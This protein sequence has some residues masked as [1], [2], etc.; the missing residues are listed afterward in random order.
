MAITPDNLSELSPTDVATTYAIATQYMAET[1]PGIETAR[2]AFSDL[3]LLPLSQLLAVDQLTFSRLQQS[4][5]LLQIQ[6][7]PALADTSIVDAAI[8]NYNITRE[9]GTTATGSVTVVVSQPVPVVLAAGVT[10][11]AGNQQFVTTS[12]IV[13]SPVANPLAGPNDVVMSPT[14][15]GNYSFTVPA[16][17]SAA[18]VAGNISQNTKLTPSVSPTYFVTCYAAV[19]FT[20]GYDTETNAQLIARLQIG[21]AG[22]SCGGAT[23]LLAYIKGQQA[24]ARTLFYSFVGAGDP[25]M[26]RDRYGLLP[27]SSGG[28]VDIYARPADLPVTLPIQMVAT[29]IAAG[30]IW[31]VSVS[32]TALPGFYSVQQVV[33]ANNTVCSVLSVVRGLS[34]TGDP[35][36]PTITNIQDGVYSA[37]QTAAVQFQNPTTPVTA[38]IGSQ[39]NVTVYLTGMPQIGQLQQLFTNPVTR[40][41][42]AS[43]LVKAATPCNVG[44]GVT[45]HL[46]SSAGPVDD[47]SIS[48]A[49]LNAVNNLD[50]GSPLYGSIIEAAIQ[51]FL[52]SGQYIAR[53]DLRGTIVDATGQSQA[54]VSDRA[55][56][57]PEQPANLVSCRTTAFILNPADISI[58]ST[59]VG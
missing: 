24:F 57:I 30:G 43:I 10:F 50:F 13:A 22:Q 4:M 56:C 45:L 17:A 59:S 53:L 26:R 36:P 23:N 16:V 38:T 46:T 18:G 19:D 14:T 9:Q 54:I 7:N 20:G 21:E 2:G 29:L 5:S 49:I 37:Y 1:N 40:P 8:S 47:S 31:Q 58:V 55:L 11:T 39:E 48:T 12:A 6:A 44:V 52:T 34:F 32:N 3:I 35:Y 27:V 33:S 28:C 51:P 41:L 42:A 15:G 25:E